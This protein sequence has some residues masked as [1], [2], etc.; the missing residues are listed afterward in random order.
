M[1][2]SGSGSGSEGGIGTSRSES[3]RQTNEEDVNMGHLVSIADSA[4]SSDMGRR[5]SATSARSSEFKRSRSGRLDSELTTGFEDLLWCETVPLCDSS[6]CK[7]REASCLCIGRWKLAVILGSVSFVSC[8]GGGALWVARN[9][10][11]NQCPLRSL[12]GLPL[13]LCNATAPRPT[14]DPLINSSRGERLWELE[15]EELKTCRE[16]NQE[17]FWWQYPE[18][19]NWCWLGLK[20][21]CHAMLQEPRPWSEVHDLAEAENLVPQR[22]GDPFFPLKG[23]DLCDRKE[24]GQSRPWTA[25]ERLAARAW[26]DSHVAVYV[27]SLP[28][29][30]AGRWKMISKRLRSLGICFTHVTGVDVRSLGSLELAKESGWVLESFNYSRAQEKAY[31]E[32]YQMGAI[33]GTVGVTAAHFKAH[34]EIISD[35]RP[36]AVVFEDDVNPSSDFVE[37]L[38]SLVNVELPCDWEVVSLMSTCPYGR[39]LSPHLMRV[40]PDANEPEWRCR[41]GVNWGAQGMLYRTSALPHLRERWQSIVFDEERPHCLNMD[42]ALASLSNEFAYYAVPAVQ[43]PGFI[44]LSDLGSVRFTINAAA[45]SGEF[46]VDDSG[47]SVRSPLQ[48]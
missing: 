32:K 29:E 40:E 19:R 4:R 12:E 3:R 13:A 48:L 5:G 15:E 36:L 23:A 41:Q 6:L 34:A 22:H 14:L 39:C 25:A 30:V 8:V 27:V 9:A 33:L 44:S 42:T 21:K 10:W 28:G 2:S 1:Q 37:R 18:D 31:S 46:S 47:E 24:L 26:F 11:S 43:N 7:Q 45:A 17:Q 16:R 20:A 35:N 38:W